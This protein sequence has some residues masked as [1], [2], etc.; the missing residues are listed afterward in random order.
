MPYEKRQVDAFKLLGFHDNILKKQNELLDFIQL[1]IFKTKKVDL[2]IYN[3]NINF[4][5]Y[6][7]QSQEKPVNQHISRGPSK[8]YLDTPQDNQ[9]DIKDEHEMLH[10]Q[11]SH[12]SHNVI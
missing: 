4:D 11:I 5:D 7:Q 2:S 12:R 1:A 9:I 6:L 3:R 8:P 10:N